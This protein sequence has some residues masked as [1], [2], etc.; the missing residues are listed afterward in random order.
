M[1]DATP[2]A[3]P[4]RTLE[5]CF[6]GVVPATIATCSPEGV[7][8]I[9]PLS[10]VHYVDDTH[11][12]LSFQFFN[13]TRENVR[14]NPLVQIIVLH[15]TSMRQY[16][17]HATYERTEREG[18]VFERM[19]ANLAAVASMTGM[20]AVFRLQ[21]SDIYAIRHIE[22]L[23]CDLDL[24]ESRPPADHVAALE[25]LSE[26]LAG[27]DDLESLLDTTLAGIAELLGHSHSMIL[28]ADEGGARL[29]AVASHGFSES[30][31]G[32]EIAFGE[33]LVGSAAR[34]QTVIRVTSLR[35]ARVMLE[36]VRATS[37]ERG[38]T[39]DGEREIPLPGLSDAASE[40]AVPILAR[41][42]TIGVLCVQSTTPGRFTLADEQALTTLCR[43]LATSIQLRHGQ[44][45]RADAGAVRS[46]A[47]R[48]TGAD[49]MQIRHHA[50][51]DSVFVDG[52]YLVKGLPGRILFRLL[53][54][55]ERDGRV[56][57]TNRELRLD[58]SLH[59]SGY[60][61]NLEARLILLRR[62]LEERCPAL[63]LARTGR[64][65]FRLELSRA[66]ELV[67]AA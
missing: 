8:N 17:I 63:R 31:V 27:C 61:D 9:T 36:A 20:A 60:R 7:P 50:S 25:T 37:I 40:L 6:R 44:G 23:D 47:P 62:R 39:L 54:L 56:D 10:I 33:G 41:D 14:T 48:A 65:R 11:L 49:A 67:R 4:L 12:A 29:Y 28:F 66:F 42:R 35:A 46:Y 19:R 32:A 34:E 52:E 15:P 59:L 51:D 26:R 64:G 53:S 3:I 30:G 24:A 58:E 13:K 21:G 38:A 18:A 1:A 5:P 55:H 2:S 57:F 16:R 22:E 45:S 43:Y